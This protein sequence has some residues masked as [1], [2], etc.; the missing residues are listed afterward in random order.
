VSRLE[1][2]LEASGTL[3]QEDECLC[4]LWG[5][6]HALWVAIKYP[7]FAYFS[8]ALDRMDALAWQAMPYLTFTPW[9]HSPL[10]PPFVRPG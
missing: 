4:L 2:N 9:I 7:F 1:A 8:F 5:F 6:V 10:P 3:Q